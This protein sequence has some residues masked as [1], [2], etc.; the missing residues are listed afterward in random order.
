MR[1]PKSRKD[2]I[3]KDL[4]AF[5]KLEGEEL[6][7]YLN[8]VKR[9]TG[10]HGSKKDYKRHP[11]HKNKGYDKYWNRNK[12]WRNNIINIIVILYNFNDYIYENKHQF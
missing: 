7:K 6:Q 4:G 8:E 5:K 10:R 12:T 11:K 9:G 2:R 3:K 1:K